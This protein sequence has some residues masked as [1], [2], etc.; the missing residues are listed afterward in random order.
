[1]NKRAELVDPVQSAAGTL[2]CGEDVRSV[3]GICGQG[4]KLVGAETV[5]AV[6]DGAPAELGELYAGAD[7]MP[8][9]APG[10]DF[11]DVN[12]VL[13]TGYVSLGATADERAAYLD[14]LRVGDALGDVFVLLEGDLKL[15]DEVGG[16]DDAV[17]EDGI[18]FA[19][20]QVV[21]GFG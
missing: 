5:G 9:V 11:I 17:V 12:R 14:G 3:A 21:A 2:L 6:V 7:V 16:D 10:D 15:V 4:G 18:V 8:A 1:M 20:A 13:S 19:R